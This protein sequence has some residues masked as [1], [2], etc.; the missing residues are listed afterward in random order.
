MFQHNS[1]IN[2]NQTYQRRDLEQNAEIF[3]KLKTLIYK[4]E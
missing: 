2:Y 3:W 4:I 1:E